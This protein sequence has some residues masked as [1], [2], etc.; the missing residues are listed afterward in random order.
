MEGQAKVDAQ[1]RKVNLVFQL[2]LVLHQD[3][4]VNVALLDPQAFLE[5]KD[6]LDMKEGLVLMD[7]LAK[8]AAL[9]HQDL[10]DLE[11]QLDFQESLEVTVRVV[12][13]EGLELNIQQ[14]LALRVFQVLQD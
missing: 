11:E 13:L 9:V 3:M 2:L 4:S 10:L 12:L 5:S 6:R 1:G 8:V 14:C 7:P